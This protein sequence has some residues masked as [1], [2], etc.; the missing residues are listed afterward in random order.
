[1]DD[2]AFQQSQQP[3]KQPI[4]RSN[5]SIL[6]ALRG[7]G[8]G[9]TKTV[10]KDVI[11][12]SAT[13][14]LASLF[15]TVPKQGEIKPNQSVDMLRRERAPLPRFI[16][17]EVKRQPYV[18]VEETNLKPQIDAIRAELKLL[19]SSLKS[20]NTEIQKAVTEVPVAPGVYH[21]N[22]FERLKSML[23]ILREQIEDSS[24]WLSLQNNRKQKKGYWGMYKKHGTSFGLSHERNLATQAG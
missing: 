21:L 18:R 3:K 24:S 19:A 1:M 9:V 20:L 8:G 2:S 14:A 17:P 22:F 11:A 4:T 23:K 7:I 5:D 16:R 15:G 6:E 10:A 13:D 12:R